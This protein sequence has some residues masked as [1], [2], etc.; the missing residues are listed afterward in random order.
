MI[1]AFRRTGV[2]WWTKWRDCEY[3]WRIEINKI[4]NSTLCSPSTFSSTNAWAIPISACN[5]V[6]PK[7]FCW[8]DPGIRLWLAQLLCFTGWSTIKVEDVWD[9][10]TL[11]RRNRDRHERTRV[12]VWNIFYGAHRSPIPLACAMSILVQSPTHH[13]N[14]DASRCGRCCG[15]IGGMNVQTQLYRRVA[16]ENGWLEDFLVSFGGPAYF[17]GQTCC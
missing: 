1:F 12:V 4:R 16:P 5:V 17:Q 10:L 9:S 14:S 8:I 6:I 15:R 3:E 13:G 2:S 11:C 7:G